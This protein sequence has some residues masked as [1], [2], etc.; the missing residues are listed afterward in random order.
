MSKYRFSHLVKLTFLIIFVLQTNAFAK[1]EWFEVQSKNFYL[2]GNASDKDIRRVATKLEQFREVFTK[3]FP[4]MNFSSP[5][6]TTVIVF[7]SGKAYKPYKPV[8]AAGETND[9]VA[10]YFM[11]REE[12]NYIT[13]SVEGEKQ[14]TYS[15]IF[16]E[17]VHYLVNNNLGRGKVPP[18]FNEGIAEY[19][20]Q[21]SIENDQKVTLGGLNNNHLYS[22]QQTKMIP[23]DQFFNIDYFSLHQQGK[24]SVN[25]YY[26]QAWA[27]MHYLMNGNQGK[28]QPQLTTFL[29]VVMNGK[30]PREA[31]QQTFQLD[32]A[33]ME[34][35][36]REYVRR[37]SY[38]A[39]T[40]DAKKKMVYDDVLK[41]QPISEASA[42]AH[43][44]DLLYHSNRLPESEKHLME[45]LNAEPDSVL[46]NTALGLVKMRQK[47]FDEAKIY[48]E[49][50]V[51]TDSKNHLAFYQHA[52]ILSR[53]GMNESNFIRGYA[54]ETYNKMRDSLAKAMKLKADFPESYRLLAFINMVRNENLDEALSAMKKALQY[55]PG[56]Q[57][58]QLNLADLYVR[59]NEFD[60]AISIIE[61]VVETADEPQLRAQ[62]ENSLQR[63]QTYKQQVEA[64]K[65][66][67]AIGTIKTI[68]AT[69]DKPPT[70]EELK[71]LQADAEYEALS[72]ALRK[73]QTGEKRII[74]YLSKIECVGANIAYLIK[75]EGKIIKLTS[76]DFE[77]LF[78]MTYIPADDLQFGCGTIK[79]DYY[80]VFTYKP[81]ENSKTKTIGEIVSIELVSE[82]FK[83][84]EDK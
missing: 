48:I 61:N 21:F 31:F 50:A 55:A 52:Y 41:S 75:S 84:R 60:K 35:E 45:S 43:L 74:G 9:W 27:L 65:N 16:H 70:E 76:K 36:L 64:Y 68:V 6:P 46:A 77:G 20:D 73:P 44:G 10:G 62:A 14:Q 18:W 13:L 11:S 5:V 17:Y 38:I 82:S 78:L 4:K 32:Y 58:Y 80:G 23:F 26:A 49:K 57:Y 54:D 34:K 28:R 1:D 67:G 39:F 56:N 59:K 24:H 40:Y 37:N 42:K 53:E 2:I 7:K 63:L 81:G 12:I 25:I 22:L 66:Q 15:T 3:L 72:E 79:K 29:N 69:G 19:Y 8:N 83:F 33:A 30:Q 51:A 71:K 47:K